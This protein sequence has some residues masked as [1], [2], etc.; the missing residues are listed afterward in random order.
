MADS[1]WKVWERRVVARAQER[2]LPWDRRLRLGDNHDLLDVDG[3]LPDGWLIGAKSISRTATFGTKISEAM[4]QCDQALVNIGRPYETDGKGRRLVDC[5]GIV[6]VQVMQRAGYPTGKAYV[7]TEYDYFL[8][9]AVERRDE[10][11]RS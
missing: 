10:R 9:L 5:G 4:D 3:C 6:P 7:V 1:A 11:S 8:D 2:G